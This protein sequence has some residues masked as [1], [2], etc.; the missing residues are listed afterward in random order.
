MRPFKINAKSEGV[1]NTV[2]PAMHASQMQ[3]K[4]KPL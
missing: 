3:K 4:I 2:V 1:A